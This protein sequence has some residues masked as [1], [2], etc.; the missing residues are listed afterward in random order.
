MRVTNKY[1]LPIALVRAMSRDDYTKGKSDYSV[2]GLLT[3]PKVALL[4]EQY[5][6][7][8]E[9][10]ISDKMYTFLGTA[11]HKVMEDTVMPENCTYE[12]RLYADID[13]TT[14]SGAIDIQERIPA[15][16]IVWDYK[17]TSV[18]SVMNE[19]AEWVQ[20]LNMYKWFVETVKKERV[21]GLKICAFLRDWSGNKTGENY[22]E[23]SIV[24]VDIPLWSATEAQ[25]FIRNRLNAH[26]E[27]K[28]VMDFGQEPPPCSDKERWM[29]ETTFAVKREGRK[30]A[31]RV[32]TS[33][34]EAKEMAEKEKGYV[35]TRLGEPRRCA[36]N[37]CGVAEWCKQYQGEKNGS[38]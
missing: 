11:L 22:P 1:D 26:K 35:E 2:T 19:K 16:T 25:E 27:A 8:M 12:E 6:D 34:Q 7:R 24:I 5:N 23:A 33:E 21:V 15:G 3:P 32:L 9:M 10:D 18:W 37:Y 14:I 38:N 28:M 4:R 20:Q 31:I 13:G 36:G 30:T 29:S 17:V